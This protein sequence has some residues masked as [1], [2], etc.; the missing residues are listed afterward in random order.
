[1]DFVEGLPFS[2]G[3]Q[4]IMV[5][6]DRLSKSAHFMALSHPYTAKEVA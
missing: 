2:Q 6:V 3:K 1:M 5:A 4:V